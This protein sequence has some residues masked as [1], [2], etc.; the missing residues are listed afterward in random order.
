MPS[1][2]IKAR[3]IPSTLFMAGIIIFPTIDFRKFH[4]AIRTL[5]AFIRGKDFLCAIGVTHMQ[6]AAER[7]LL[8]IEIADM[9]EGQHALVPASPQMSAEHILTGAQKFRHLISLIAQALLISRPARCELIP[10]HPLAIDEEL[11]KA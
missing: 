9:M 6:F 5:P 8:P 4:G 10:P 2:G 11:I 3:L 7:R 1:R